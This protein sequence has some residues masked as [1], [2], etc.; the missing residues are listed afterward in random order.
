MPATKSKAGIPCLVEGH[1]PITTKLAVAG[2]WRDVS[3]KDIYEH[4]VL[5]G[6]KGLFDI[7]LSLKDTRKL[8]SDLTTAIE[9]QTTP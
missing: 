6:V 1:G 8:V 5:I 9:A 7:V 2:G 4:A 3:K